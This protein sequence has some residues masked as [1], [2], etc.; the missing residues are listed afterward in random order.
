[1]SVMNLE[2]PFQGISQ[3]NYHLSGIR[4]NL[5]SINSS[6]YKMNQVTKTFKTKI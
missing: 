1:M 5:H 2:K 6:G 4:N 3:K